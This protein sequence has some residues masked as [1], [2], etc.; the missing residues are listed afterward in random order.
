MGILLF[1]GLTG[2]LLPW[3][4]VAQLTLQTLTEALD[5]L[6]LLAAPPSRLL[7][8]G[9]V[10]PWLFYLSLATH[11]M[12]TTVLT[13][14]LAAHVLSSRRRRLWPR[15]RLGVIVLGLILLLSLLRPVGREGPAELTSLPAKI[16]LDLFYL[17]WLP[18]S[19][20]LGPEAAAAL[21]LLV[22]LVLLFLPLAVGRKVGD[23]GDGPGGR[24]R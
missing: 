9:N 11:A 16:T 10:K 8:P 18:L 24:T 14:V 3:D 6:P 17:F 7:V 20:R 2:Y 21:V 12:F 1:L 13:G 4:R 19:D 5:R 15:A 23:Q 22:P